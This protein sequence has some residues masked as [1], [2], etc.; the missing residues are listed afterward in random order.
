MNRPL[1]PAPFTTLRAPDPDG[2][3]GGFTR[4]PAWAYIPTSYTLDAP[5]VHHLLRS[6]GYPRAEMLHMGCQPSVLA[7]DGDPWVPLHDAVAIFGAICADHLHESRCDDVWEMR[8]GLAVVR[9]WF[10][11]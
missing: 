5:G 6:A 10:T 9:A 1:A 11:A 2:W 4:R 7:T 3:R 8:E